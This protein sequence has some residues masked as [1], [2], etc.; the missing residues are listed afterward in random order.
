MTNHPA[1][2]VLDLPGMT[3]AALGPDLFRRVLHCTRCAAEIYAP[4]RHELGATYDPV[5]HEKTGYRVIVP[6]RMTAMRI[7]L[8]HD[9]ARQ[10]RP[11][12]W[13]AT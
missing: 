7:R 2:Y 1:S 3:P 10:C 6:D 13:V 5:T 4:G 11:M 12:P 9:L 8:C